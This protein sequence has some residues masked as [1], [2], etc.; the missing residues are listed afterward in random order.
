MFTWEE[1]R[2]VGAHHYGDYL[3]G[4]NLFYVRLADGFIIPFGLCGFEADYN[5]D[6]DSI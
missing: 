3:P 4:D 5:L 1:I 2:H 6:K